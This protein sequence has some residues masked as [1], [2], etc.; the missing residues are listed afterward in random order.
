MS[1]APV[2]PA[3]EVKAEVQQQPAATPEPVASAP[4]TTAPPE[5]EVKQVTKTLT[6]DEV[7]EIVRKEKAKAEARAERRANKFYQDA[8]ERLIPKEK[9]EPK[10]SDGRPKQSDYEDVDSYVTAVAEWTIEKREAAAREHQAKARHQSLSEKTE[11]LYQKASEIEG[12]DRDE[13]DALPLTPAIAAAVTDSEVAHELMA[14]MVKNSGDVLRISRLPPARQAAEIGKLETKME[15]MAEEAAAAKKKSL[16]SKLPD[17]P[18]PIGGK[19]A[20]SKN[21][22]DMTD[23]EYEKWRK[24]GTG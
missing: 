11:V 5:S 22:A 3:P 13:F 12:F 19:K 14:F 21:P 1:E 8:L 10:P 4:E 6:Q 16:E 20:G 18:T 9:A 15:R 17:P 24:S 7:N 2:A 23:A